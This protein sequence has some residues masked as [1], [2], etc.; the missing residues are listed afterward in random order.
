MGLYKDNLTDDLE[1]AQL[2]VGKVGKQP[3]STVTNVDLDHRRKDFESHFEIQDNSPA[4]NKTIDHSRGKLDQN[5]A[6]V[7]KTLNATWDMYDQS[8]D[9]ASKKE[10]QYRIKNLG[11]GMG[12]RRA[13][14]SE[15]HWGFDGG[16][17]I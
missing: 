8:P 16:E 6:K 17:D 7:L 15:S 9:S 12:G 3:L 1:E 2:N 4:P 13:A 5:Q 11:D 14:N 10:N